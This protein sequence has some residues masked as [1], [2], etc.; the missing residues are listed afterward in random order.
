[1]VDCKRVFL[2]LIFLSFVIEL[3]KSNQISHIGII[4]RVFR[5]THNKLESEMVRQG[6]YL[7][8]NVVRDC[9]LCVRVR[10]CVINICEAPLRVQQL[11]AFAASG[12][13]PAVEGRALNTVGATIVK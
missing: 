10:L 7:Q 9:H 4:R 2:S 6:I 5:P 3:F 1:M 8:L 11:T 12:T 13:P